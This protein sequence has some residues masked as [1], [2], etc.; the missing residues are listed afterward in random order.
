MKP[1]ADNTYLI[2]LRYADTPSIIATGLIETNAGV[3]LV[4]PGPHITLGHLDQSLAATGTQW[5][6]VRAILLTHIHLDHAGATGHLVERHPHLQVF[7]HDR[8]APH[9][10]DPTKLVRSASRLFGDIEA[11]WGSVLPVPSDRLSVLEGTGRHRL[12][13]G[14]IEVAYTP[15]HASHHVSYLDTQTGLAFVGD[16]AGAR[17]LDHPI[18][19]PATPPPDIDVPT[20]LESLTKILEWGPERLFLTHFGVANDPAWH[21]ARL[22][23]ALDEWS[24]LVRGS[25]EESQDDD[26]AAI[27]F[28]DGIGRNLRAEISDELAAAYE[29]AA[30]P[31]LSWYGLARYWRKRAESS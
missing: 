25:V 5:N 12:F 13:E 8:G 4:D 18:V 3:A 28:A 30:A 15:G 19:V 2:D 6:D 9:V 10:V 21:A 23:E 11:V 16:A 26:A 14:R 27:A 31:N 29:R 20:I 24:G 17:I 7:V 1:I 22:G